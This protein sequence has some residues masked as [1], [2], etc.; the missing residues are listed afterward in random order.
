MTYHELVQKLRLQRR[1]LVEGHVS[2]NGFMNRCR[3]IKREYKRTTKEK[4]K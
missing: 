1:L 3:G 4:G 2:E